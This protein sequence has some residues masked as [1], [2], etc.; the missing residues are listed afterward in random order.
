MG[1]TARCSTAGSEVTLEVPFSSAGDLGRVLT[2]GAVA[3][4][5]GGRGARAAFQGG[6]SGVFVAVLQYR[7]K[8]CGPLGFHSDPEST[9]C[10]TPRGI[11]IALLK[12]PG[13]AKRRGS[14]LQFPSVLTTA[15][16]AHHCPKL[17]LHLFLFFWSDE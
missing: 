8:T 1:S 11:Q 12:K 7:G 14:V 10:K 17:F 13:L 16:V 4:G 5:E 15:T 9:P 3:A 2:A 6:G